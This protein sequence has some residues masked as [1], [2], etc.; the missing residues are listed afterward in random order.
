MQRGWGVRRIATFY[1]L[2]TLV[3]GLISV[4]VSDVYIVQTTFLLAG[5]VAFFIIVLNILTLREKSADI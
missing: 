5:G 3:F 2:T 4:L 1:W